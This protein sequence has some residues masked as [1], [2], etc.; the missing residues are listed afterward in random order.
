M[1]LI[2]PEIGSPSETSSDSSESR[3][4]PLLLHQDHLDPELYDTL[5]QSE[6]PFLAPMFLL[7]LT[8][9]GNLTMDR[10]QAQR[11]A[12]GK[13]RRVKVTEDAGNR[14]S[15]LRTMRTYER[16]FFAENLMYSSA[17][18]TIYLELP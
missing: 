15:R 8:K 3:F 13:G 2:R 17:Q 7:P 9:T 11:E 18:C 1:G 5:R 10:E 16:F 4:H 14:V 12:G 6:N